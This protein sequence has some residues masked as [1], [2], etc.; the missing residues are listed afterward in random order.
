MKKVK[1]KVKVVAMTSAL[2]VGIA[3]FG[4]SYMTNAEQQIESSDNS[5][6]LNVEKLDRDT[7]KIYLSNFT[8]L[9]KS[10]Q[11]SLKIDEGNVKFIDDQIKWLSNEDED[12]ETVKKHYKIDDSKK[13]IDFFI[14]SDE[15]INSDGGIVE[16]CEIDVSKDESIVEKLFKSA[17]DG[18][19]KIVPNEGNDEAYSYV[20]YSTNKRVGG[21]NI[22]NASDDK[23][24]IN[25]VKTL[26]LHHKD[27]L[28]SKSSI[29]KLL[30]SIGIDLFEDLIKVK[31]AD[32][33]AMNYSNEKKKI[34]E[35]N[36]IE[37][38]YNQIISENECF[39][40]KDLNINGKDLINIGVSRGKDIGIML[41]YLLEEVMKNNNLNV[42]EKLIDMAIEEL[43]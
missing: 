28:K 31:R 10:L 39:N 7:V 15:P 2:A 17:S 21:N 32:I 3:G 29:K 19:Y 16:I 4:V 18:S 27:I 23:L 24:T 25:K 1:S 34:S 14:L 6:Q 13:E 9:A 42:K 37:K 12:S 30:N 36:I 11:L 20:T 40:L 22:V 41:N 26:I 43:N 35:I 5:I 33:Y 8:D 38:K